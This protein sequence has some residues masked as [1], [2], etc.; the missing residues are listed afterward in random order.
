MCVQATNAFWSSVLDE[1][2]CHCVSEDQLTAAL[3]NAFALNLNPEEF[4]YTFFFRYSMIE[5]L[6]IL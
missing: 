1:Y 4:R 3:F 2:S 6:D 5:L